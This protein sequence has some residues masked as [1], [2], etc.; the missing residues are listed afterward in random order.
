MSCVFDRLGRL[1]TRRPRTI[2]AVWAVFALLCALT[3]LMGVTGQDLFERL[4]TGEPTV[5]GSESQEGR[6]ILAD[7][8]DSGTQVSFV[9]Q[10]A[11]LTDPDQVTAIGEALAPA[12]ADLA[13]I[14]GVDTVVDAFLL[15]DTVANPAA[16]GLVSTARDGF[17]MVVMLEPTLTEEAEE[18]AHD[19]VVARLERVPGELSAAVP[20]VTGIASSSAIL[21]QEVVDQVREDLVTG[22]TVALPVALAIMVLVFAGFLSA[23]LPLVGALA[24]IVGGLGV[25]LAMTYAID[26]DSFV[27]N[28]VTV[29]G[30]G[31]SIDYGLLIVS[32]FREEAH[33]LLA[34]T[35]AGTSVTPPAGLRR[36]RRHRG[37]TVEQAVR[38]TVATA[39]RTVAFSAVTVA[40]AVSGLLLL[41]PEVLRSI[42][43]AGVA[44]VLLAVLSAITLVPALLMLLGERML[45]P[46]L[47][48]RVPGLRRVVNGLGDVAPEDGVFSRLA[49]GVH[50]HPWIV[51]VGTLAVLGL[52]ASPV[53]GL[54]MRNSTTELLPS[55]SP[56]RDYIATLAADYPAA[57][58]PDVTVVARAGADEVATLAEGVTTLEHVADVAA[59]VALDGYS[60]LNVFVDTDD[61]GSLEAAAVVQDIRALDPGFET[62]VVGQAANQLDFNA[63]L[64]EGLP[65]AGGI[66][67]LAVLVLIFLMT[68]SVLVP[69]KAIVVNVLSLA[70]SLGVT[71]WVFQEGHGADL[72]GFTPL[73]GLESYVVAVVV[74]FGFGLAMDYEVFLISRIK[75]YW[76]AG[77]SN[78]EAVEKGLQRSGRIIT[79]AALIIVAVFAGFMAGDLIVIKQVGFALAITVLV[80]ATLV[81]MLLVPA[82]MT[83][84][85]KWNWWAP[86]P[87]ARL[88]DRLKIVH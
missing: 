43:A 11:D 79:S 52:L 22:E 86:A 57:T 54:Q 37:H 14:H 77:Y 12:H 39:G 74:A 76:D 32:R 8:E 56:Q 62:W 40:L 58:A 75:E 51:L 80:D 88:Y 87:L 78:D 34:E 36:R 65:I 13:E 5:P 60:V 9:V 71:V 27:I 82:T 61:A 28:V 10:G 16:A 33:R 30:L 38:T 55:Q 72:L 69:V 41:R 2:V 7:A 23:G 84:L 46:S 47:L 50:A 19:L 48:G 68:G 45:R 70:A 21:A 20:G 66:I 64:V 85:G 49:R 29:L 4:R 83:L 26:I 24:S 6:E 25:L 1:A 81:R 73:S 31:L 42:A 18:S 15:P 3:A 67:V 35:A 17:L 44:V 59:P 63:A 53:A